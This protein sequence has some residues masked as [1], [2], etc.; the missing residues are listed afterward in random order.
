MNGHDPVTRLRLMEQV[1][2][3]LADCSRQIIK[4][5]LPIEEGAVSTALGSIG[6]WL[7]LAARYGP[8]WEQRQLGHLA[9]HSHDATKELIQKGRYKG[10]IT[11]ESVTL[12]FRSAPPPEP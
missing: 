8:D 10:T 7:M 9:K 11:A 5:E 2:G 1:F 12:A 3:A 4:S 6:A